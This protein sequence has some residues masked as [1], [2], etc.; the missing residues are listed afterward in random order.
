[1]NRIYEHLLTRGG[2]ASH[3]II[4]GSEVEKTERNQ[5]VVREVVMW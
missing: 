5:F 4:T 1:M 3:H 2:D